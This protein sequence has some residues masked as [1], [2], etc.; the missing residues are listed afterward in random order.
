MSSYVVY[1]YGRLIALLRNATG[2]LCPAGGSV[3]NMYAINLARHN[4]FPSVKRS[5]LSGLPPL[6]ILTSEKV[7]L[8]LPSLSLSFVLVMMAFYRVSHMFPCIGKIYVFKHETIFI[9]II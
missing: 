7:G 6:C 5:G 4:M 8:P 3:S 1:W 2:S 9:Y